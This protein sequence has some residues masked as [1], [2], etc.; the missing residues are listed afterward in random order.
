MYRHSRRHRAERDDR[1]R[2]GKEGCKRAG[3]AEKYDRPDGARSARRGGERR[4]GKRAGT[5]R[6]RLSGGRLHRPRRYT[7]HSGFELKGAGSGAYG[8]K[9]SLRKGRPDRPARGRAVGRP[10]QHGL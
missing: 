5:R 8:R 9:R 3:S 10:Y 7:D 4:A 1:R 2:A 6:H